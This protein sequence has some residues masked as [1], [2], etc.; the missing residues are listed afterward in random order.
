[1]NVINTINIKNKVQWDKWHRNCDKNKTGTS[2]I[3][4]IYIDGTEK[5][6]LYRSENKAYFYYYPGKR[7]RTNIIEV[8]FSYQT[9]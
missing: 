6:R 7:N 3:I 2:I 1:M 4:I 8:L 5:H 9:P